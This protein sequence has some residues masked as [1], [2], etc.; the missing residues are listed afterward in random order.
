M[1]LLVFLIVTAIFIIPFT[2]ALFYI[3]IGIRSYMTGKKENDKAKLVGGTNTI[4][5][6]LLAAVAVFFV[7][8]IIMDS[9]G[10]KIW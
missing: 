1:L 2:A 5:Y 4:A 3:F 7:W 10:I 6:S 8:Y 9:F